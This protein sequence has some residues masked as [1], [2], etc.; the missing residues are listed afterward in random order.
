MDFN[1][2]TATITMKDG[3]KFDE[4]AMAK[5]LKAQGYGGKVKA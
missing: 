1:A 4:A 2:K 3:V 5:A